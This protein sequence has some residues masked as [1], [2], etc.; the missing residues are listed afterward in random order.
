MKKAWFLNATQC[1]VRRA[2]CVPGY[3]ELLSVKTKERKKAYKN[4]TVSNPKRMFIGVKDFGNTV[5]PTEDGMT[6]TFKAV[7]AHLTQ[8]PLTMTMSQ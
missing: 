6:R 1:K 7:D 8:A 2:C 4:I 3:S 5:K